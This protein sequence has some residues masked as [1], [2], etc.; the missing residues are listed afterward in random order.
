Y[1]LFAPS[2]QRPL[3]LVFFLLTFARRAGRRVTFSP[4]QL[5]RQRLYQR[6]VVVVGAVDRGRDL[7]GIEQAAR[8]RSKQRR[9]GHRIDLAA[10][11][12]EVEG[13]GRY[14]HGHAVVQVGELSVG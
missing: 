3:P 12:P 10:V 11:E 1:S 9:G 4:W 2:E 8:A 13:V 5:L 14:D 7:I 6:R